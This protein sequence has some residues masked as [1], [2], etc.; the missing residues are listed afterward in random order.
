M[1]L[2]FL[3]LEEKDCF[4]IIPLRWIECYVLIKNTTHTIKP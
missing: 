2:L 3:W 4:V 1:V